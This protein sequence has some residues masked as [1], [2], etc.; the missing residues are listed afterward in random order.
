M[1]KNLKTLPFKEGETYYGFKIERIVPLSSQK[2]T[3]I[4]ASH[5]VSGLEVLQFY[6]DDRENL[7]AFCFSTIPEN[8][9]G[10]PHILEHSVLSGSKKF[11][12]KDPFQAFSSGSV[13]TFL[14]ALTGPFITYYPAASILEKDYFNLME[15]YGDSVFNPLLSKEIFYQEGL[16]IEI[17]QK[18]QPY[19]KGIVY[20][21]MQGAYSDSEEQIDDLCCKALFDGSK[22]A[23]DSG[24]IPKEIISLTYEEFLSYYKKHYSPSN[25]KLYLYGNIPLLKQLAFLEEKLFSG[26]KLPKSGRPK[27]FFYYPDVPKWSG[28][29]YFNHTIASGA[30]E[31]APYN[32]ILNWLLPVKVDP[33]YSVVTKLIETILLGG[34]GAP[35]YRALMDSKLGED[36][37]SVTGFDDQCGFF[38]FS[39]GMKGVKVHQQDEVEQFILKQLKEICEKKIE[40]QAIE[41]ALRRFEFS[42]RKWKGKYPIGLIRL[43]RCSKA[44]LANEDPLPYIDP[45]PAIRQLRKEL[46]RHPHF[47]EEFISKNI[48]DNDQLAVVRVKEDPSHQRYVDQQI[49]TVVANQLRQYQKIQPDFP[50]SQLKSFYEYQN[51]KDDVKL[52]AKIPHIKRDDFPHRLNSY[53][54]CV[55]PLDFNSHITNYL[56]F[57][58]R[59]CYF[60]IIISLNNLS[61]NEKLLLS[62]LSDIMSQSSLP[63]MSLEEVG[64]KIALLM[65]KYNTTFE[66]GTSFGMPQGAGDIFLL[67]INIESGFEYIT[68]A[69][70]FVFELIENSLL[71]DKARL[72]EYILSNRND[73]KLSLS[74]DCL[75]YAIDRCAMAFS[76]TSCNDDFV[77]GLQ[78]YAFLEHLYHCNDDE[79][80]ALVGDLETLRNKL[81]D[82]S[83]I[84]FFCCAG[85][86]AASKNQTAIIELC[87]SFLA[88]RAKIVTKRKK[89]NKISQDY[90]AAIAKKNSWIKNIEYK[91]CEIFSLSVEVAY[92]VLAIPC[93]PIT[94]PYYASAQVL[95]KIIS[96]RYLWQ[97]VRMKGGAYGS[98][99]YCSPYEG[100]LLFYSYRDPHIGATFNHFRSALSYYS[101]TFATDEE[102]EDAVVAILSHSLRPLRPH[103]RAL[104]AY[105]HKI[106]KITLKERKRSQQAL[107]QVTKESI[108]FVSNKLLQSMSQATATVFCKKTQI[109]QERKEIAAFGFKKIVEYRL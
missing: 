6:C 89:S 22:A 21:E 41:G 51:K 38:S 80:Q 43:L 104:I 87:N 44:W 70:E 35:L 29:K 11:P 12:L 64:Q 58:N 18:G 15:L 101:N 14:N 105:G 25:C 10:I 100:Y 61:D 1:M 32:V 92:N 84:S 24:G 106:Y 39:L 91:S 96:N 94:D 8:D 67:K 54:V 63:N 26:L 79:R 98:H 55:T 57:T 107:L 40:P 50:Q 102:I 73:A 3:A 72:E 95:A 4:F 90:Y 53:P 23:Y 76:Q 62:M 9:K 83:R 59:I 86:G 31:K 77:G 68:Q 85:G 30:L 52:L 109:K 99:C 66:S 33:F 88:R 78:E 47:L 69:I 75:S 36:I 46:K 74:S 34:V 60:S 81:L 13:N 65:G 103:E 37:S 7:F 56:S 108:R 2:A 71:G 17:D 20:N 16:R 48:L 45:A 42:L 28:K 19:P 5:E 82:P 97:N 93:M 27:N 49:E